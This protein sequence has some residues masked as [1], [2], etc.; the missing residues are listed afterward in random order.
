MKTEKRSLEMEMLRSLKTSDN[1]FR[2]GEEVRKDQLHVFKRSMGQ[3]KMEEITI[4]F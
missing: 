1:N 2:T 4:L 3:I